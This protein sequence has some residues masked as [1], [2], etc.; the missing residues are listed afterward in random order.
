MRTFFAVCALLLVG[1][2]VAFADSIP[3]IVNPQSG[4]IGESA[5][6]RIVYNDSG[7]DIQSGEVVVWDSTDTDFIQSGRPFITTTTTVDDPWT[8]GVIA[9][10]ICRASSQ[11]EIIVSGPAFV[12]C[13][14]N[15]DAVGIN[16]TVGTSGIA[17]QCGDYTPAANKTSLGLAAQAGNG[18]DYDYILVY[19]NIG[20]I[21]EQ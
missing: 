2:G 18:V 16:T 6:K 17:G 9:D 20:G 15:S 11:C 14:D 10:N 19:V 3:Q 7:A 1:S 5:W 13:S 8:A 12:R 4:G 21:S